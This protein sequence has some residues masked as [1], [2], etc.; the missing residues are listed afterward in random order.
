MICDVAS[1][2]TGNAELT[3][4]TVVFFKYGNSGAKTRGVDRRHHTCRAAAD[5]SYT[6]CHTQLFLSY[7][8]YSSQMLSSFS[9][10]ALTSSSLARET[11]TMMALSRDRGATREST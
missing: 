7:T 9:S 3:T 10:R 2:L 8:S 6:Y 1:T 4:A 11:P 5:H